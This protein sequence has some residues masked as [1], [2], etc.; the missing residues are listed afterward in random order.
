MLKAMK[1]LNFKGQSIYLASLFLGLAFLLSLSASLNGSSNKPS[2]K[3]TPFQDQTALLPAIPEI[4]G[5]F[6]IEDYVLDST[7]V[8][9]NQSFEIKIYSLH[10]VTLLLR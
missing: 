9:G 8:C 3:E 6:L 5:D 10:L 7:F 2:Y 1:D 4:K